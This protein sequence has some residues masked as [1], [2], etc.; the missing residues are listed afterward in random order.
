MNITIYG[1]DLVGKST[2]ANRLLNR[3]G[4][5]AVLQ[6]F[7]DY[8]SKYGKMI[9]KYLNTDTD[10]MNLDTFFDFKMLYVY[11]RAL[12]MNKK[13]DHKKYMI[14]DR[15]IMDNHF[16]CNVC[17]YNNLE[18][19]EKEHLDMSIKTMCE[20]EE[21]MY[22]A[23]RDLKIIFVVK[24]KETMEK[25]I[26]DA[27]SRTLDKNDFDIDKHM[28]VNKRISNYILNTQLNRVHYLTKYYSDPEATLD[29]LVEGI[30]G[31]DTSNP[32]LYVIPVDKRYE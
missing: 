22:H 12:Y 2:L 19:R 32:I 10:K 15:Y 16:H 5:D 31:H 28:D 7:P 24:E 8:N 9:K 27:K 14:F 6:H 3:L 21:R 23:K 30:K 13:K 29:I 26:D 11:D 17:T 20:N 18:D 1:G 25:L 4:E